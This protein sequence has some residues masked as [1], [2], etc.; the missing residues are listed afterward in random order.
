MQSQFVALTYLILSDWMWLN[1]DSIMYI[2]DYCTRESWIDC[3]SMFAPL[4][5]IEILL[6]L[7]IFLCSIC[8]VV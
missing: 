6:S 3:K 7:T 5:L 1:C 4:V 2:S 8:S